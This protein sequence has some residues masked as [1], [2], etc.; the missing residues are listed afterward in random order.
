[1]I[2]LRES[3]EAELKATD[4]EH[5]LMNDEGWEQ[6]EGNEQLKLAMTVATAWQAFEDGTLSEKA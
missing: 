1:M 2:M 5:G 3:L 6:V 4:A